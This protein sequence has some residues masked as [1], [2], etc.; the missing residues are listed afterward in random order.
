[1]TLLAG[2]VADVTIILALTLVAVVALRRRPAA[3]RHAVLAAGIGAATLAPA[4]ELVVPQV[5]VF[6]WSTAQ[7]VTS[8]GLTLTSSEARDADIASDVPVPATIPWPTMLLA[9]WGLG[10]IVTLAGLITSI[11]RLAWLTAGCTP[12]NT[13]RWRE[14]ADELS[15]GWTLRRP[16][17]LLQSADPSLLV[18]CGILTPKIILPAGSAAWTDDRRRV[19]LAHELAHVRRFDGAIQLAGEIVRAFHWFNPLVWIC[20]HRLRQESE[21][22]CDDAVLCG[23]IEAT[24]YAT[25]LLAVA[26]HAVGRRHAWA[27]APAIAHPS[28]LERR[29]AAVLNQDRN[30]QPL[31]GRAWAIAAIVVMAVIVPLAATSIAP[32]TDAASVVVADAVDIALAPPSAPPEAR[33]PEVR[34]PASRART[35]AAV[36]AQAPGSISGTLMDPTGAM[37]PGVM[38][39]VTDPNLAVAL[40]TV[41][42]NTGRF[43]VRDL[44]PA[45]YELV[46]RLPGFATVTN[47]LTVTA[48]GALERRIMMPIGTVM[49]TIN[50]VCS[51]G[52]ASAPAAMRFAWD[53]VLQAIAPVVSAQENSRPAPVRVGGN[54]KAPTKI[55]DVRP[56]CPSTFIPATETRVLLTARI[57]VD[58]FMNDLK[59]SAAAADAVAPP[60][61]FTET[62]LDAVRQWK[63]T[64]TLLNGQ[65]FEANITIFVVYRRM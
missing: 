8:T 42:D 65:P 29:I 38:V 41:T 56:R 2:T 47:I 25:H 1:M 9:M 22:A 20:C 54:I 48:G 10:V 23:G 16:V 55:M 7:E 32:A 11:V 39:T 6:E 5:T 27:S 35:A 62:A 15:Q 63:F 51:T 37:L 12:V 13:G 36:A 40:A 26:R 49:E 53:R 3:L 19:V 61:E 33:A 28:T 24:D 43:V 31:T 4:L 21:Y 30:R 58:G 60:A 44:Q 14:I 50:V 17:T 18:T 57:G 52:Q 64:P 34:R 46:A 59:P 45:R